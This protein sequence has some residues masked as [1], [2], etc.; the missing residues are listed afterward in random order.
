MGILNEDEANKSNILDTFMYLDMKDSY[1][2]QDF[3]SVLD[4]I[5][6]DLIKKQ[7]T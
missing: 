6:K 7:S 5:K 3:D 2:N 1:N 4:L